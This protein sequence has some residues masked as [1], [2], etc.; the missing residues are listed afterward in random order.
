MS[1]LVG[2]FPHGVLLLFHAARAA[3]NARVAV[4]KVHALHTL[5]RSLRFKD[6]NETFLNKTTINNKCGCVR[7]IKVS[8]R[9]G[10][11][12]GAID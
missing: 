9:T 11:G 10:A 7:V 3:L 4:L 6:S 5:V 12:G 8:Y 1:A 2:V